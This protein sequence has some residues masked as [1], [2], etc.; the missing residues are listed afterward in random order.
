MITLML[1]FLTS[2]LVTIVLMPLVIK[3]FKRMRY[4][5]TILGYV[6]EHKEKNG[7]LTMGG[8]VFLLVP[9]ALSFCFLKYDVNWFMCL[10]VSVFFG[11]LGFMDDFIKIKFKQNL[12][13]RPYQKII[14]QVGISIIFAL[15]VYL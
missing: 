10:L 14:G 15:F 5:Q 3:F 2:F 8:V 6:E 4:G 1:A 12:G 13:L 9:F 11:V 7:T